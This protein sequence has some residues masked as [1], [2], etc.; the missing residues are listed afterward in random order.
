M[1]KCDNCRIVMA[2]EYGSLVG[3]ARKVG[4]YKICTA[5]DEEIRKREWLRKTEFQYLF[6]SGRVK[7][8]NSPPNYPGGSVSG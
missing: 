1:P 3:F 4:K 2:S 5:C 6:P 7:V 8:R